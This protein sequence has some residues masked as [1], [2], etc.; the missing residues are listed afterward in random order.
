M[1]NVSYQSIRA[2]ISENP[3]KAAQDCRVLL[4]RAEHDAEAYRLLGRAL[5]AL[6]QD[7]EAQQAELE[8]IDASIFDVD[9]REAALAIV[10]NRLEIAEPLLRARLRANPFDAAAIRMLAE[11][12]GRLGRN[13]DA[14]Q[15][16]G[17]A[18]RAGSPQ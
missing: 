14:E 7:A 16:R 1:Q 11:V 4:K 9:L 3:A 13:P 15:D 10:D 8:A 2:L 12:A 6:G 18:R 5:R 17:G